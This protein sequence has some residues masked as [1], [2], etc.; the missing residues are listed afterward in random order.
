M[1]GRTVTVV[2]AGLAG[3]EA[4]WQA[5]RRGIKVKLYEMRPEKLT[6]AHRSGYFAELVCSNSLRAAALENAVG[7]LKEEMRHLDSL[8]M[9]C[10]DVT[11][12][13]AGGALA[14]DRDL[15][16][17]CVT[18]RIA[19]NPLIEICR[20]E[21]TAIPEGEAVIIAT[22]PLTSDALASDI[23]RFTG[24]NCLFFYDAVAP[25]VAAESIN[26]GKVFRSSRYG[27]GEAA[28]LNC[29][30]SREEYE[31]FWEALVKAEK[32]PRKEFEKELHFEGCMP[33]EVLAARGK[34]TLLYGP[35]KPVGL[36]DPR[37][38]RRPYAVVQLR[39]E[40]A[41]ATLF[42]MVGFQTGLKW[43][44]QKRVFRLIPGLEEAEFVR[45]GVM[46]R[47]TFINSPVL[48]HPTFQTRK[49]PALFFAGQITGVEG[50]VES[51]AS[52]L[53]AGINAA[54]LLAG[55]EP[56]VFPRNTAHGSLAH[57]I[58]AAD[59]AHFQPMNINFGLF[60]PFE[61]RIRDKKER[62]RTVA[63]KALESIDRFKETLL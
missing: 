56:L 8:V 43:D 21:V 54:R 34:E 2:G 32:A 59:P 1:T 5:A 48:L 16:A 15:F 49:N 12:V 46:H 9:A 30:L 41:A 38:G 39:Q 3:A 35:M 62:Y 40:N 45:F 4:A 47:N 31:V 17:R 58:T 29:P 10:A 63:K 26:M 36:I 61:A 22:G 24:E 27:K 37:T 51:A 57:Y 11:S 50:Y 20:E 13:P 25:I 28:Y 18:E 23:S 53:M 14:V 60:P 33:V 42:N 52:G 7:L 44:E 19:G 6:P 55:K